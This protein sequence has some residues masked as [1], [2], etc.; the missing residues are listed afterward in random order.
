[1]MFVLM[2]GRE[3]F[4][5]ITVS[6]RLLRFG[7]SF[8]VIAGC[9][10]AQRTG[11]QQAASACGSLHSSGELPVCGATVVAT[12]PH[13]AQAFTQ[14]LEYYRGFLYESTGLAGRSSLRKVE[15]QTGRV[16]KK[17]VLPARYFGEGLTIFHGKIYQLTWTSRTGQLI[18][19]SVENG[20]SF[21]E[22]SRW[23]YDL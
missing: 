4:T 16:L 8:A 9:L 19:F 21:P 6:K 22:I 14:G 23:Q 3:H 1:M 18:N 2:R 11:P 7:L 12:Y 13:D 20:Q 10:A 17:I 15:L 5:Q